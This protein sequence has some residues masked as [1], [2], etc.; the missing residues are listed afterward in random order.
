MLITFEG[1]DLSGKSTQ[2]QR[3]LSR[4][5]RERYPAV[6]IREPGGTVIGEKIRTVLLDRTHD[7][8]DPRTEFLLFSASRAQLV[9]EVVRPAL[10]KGTVVI[11]DRF[12]DSSTAYQG[13][14][15]GLPLEQI[16]VI[17]RHATAGLKPD[18]TFFLDAPIAVLEA[19]RRSSRPGVDRMESNDRAFYERVRGAYLDI[20]E[21]EQR[22]VVLDGTVP[23]EE[24]E[25]QIWTMVTPALTKLREGV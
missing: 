20:A 15:R 10:A 3:L 12:F 2:A 4:L 21:R 22:V 24:L 23:V 6:L 17:N 11:S 25:Q 1:L 14:G 18:M 8:M 5:Q 19:R 13:A 16:E 7:G 9:C